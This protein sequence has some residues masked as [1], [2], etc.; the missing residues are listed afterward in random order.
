MN[1]IT[2]VLVSSKVLIGETKVD[3]NFRTSSCDHFGSDLDDV[4]SS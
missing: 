4:K 3:F 2:Y 1:Q